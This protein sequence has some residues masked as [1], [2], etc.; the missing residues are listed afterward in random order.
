MSQPAKGHEPDARFKGRDWRSVQVAEIIDPAEVRF[1]ERETSIEDCTK[2]LVRSGAPNAVLIR[3]SRKTLP[4]L[5]GLE[6][7]EE[8]VGE[9]LNGGGTA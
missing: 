2:L 7:C 3:E 8:A 1:V 5:G 6:R 4:A 9:A